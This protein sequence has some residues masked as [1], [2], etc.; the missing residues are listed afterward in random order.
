M[1][2]VIGEKYRRYF[3]NFSIAL[4]SKNFNETNK[5]IPSKD[6]SKIF[7]INYQSK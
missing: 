5:G 2:I 3:R 4:L 6:E 7:R 1:K